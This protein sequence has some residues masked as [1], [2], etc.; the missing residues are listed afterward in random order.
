MY[1]VYVLISENNNSFYVG[2]TKDIERRVQQHNRGEVKYTQVYR[3][4]RLVYYESYLV[5][6]DAK[7]REKNLKYFGR[8]FTNLK[9]RI[10][11]SLNK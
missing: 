9:K 11:K 1:H 2:Y 4:W 8:A 7:T 3:P 6:E 10:Q 5:L